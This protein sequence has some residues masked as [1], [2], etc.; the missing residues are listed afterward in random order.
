[1]GP[2][3]GKGTVQGSSMKLRTLGGFWPLRK[4]MK[5]DLWA[6]AL[7]PHGWEQ[8]KM[9]ILQEQRRSTYTRLARARRGPNFKRRADKLMKAFGGRGRG[10][11]SAS[12]GPSH[13]R[14]LLGHLC[15]AP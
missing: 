13:S 4:R 1:M 12:V 9:R 6:G 10:A 5:W 8:E 15:P 11:G 14:E 2:G 7:W 3:L